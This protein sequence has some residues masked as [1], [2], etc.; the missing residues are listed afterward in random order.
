LDESQGAE[1]GADAG[2]APHRGLMPEQ[3]RTVIL[4]QMH[5]I[6]ACYE[7]ALAKGPHP[8]GEIRIAFSIAP[9]GRIKE[10][11]VQSSTVKD[12]EVEQCTL[13]AFRAM[14]FPT[15]EKPTNV[16]F[17]FVFNRKP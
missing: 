3:I 6:E 13:R 4:G 17:P 8:G 5:T 15:A 7:I 1:T 14:Q 12:A 2:R 9:N 16:S 11:S 10:A